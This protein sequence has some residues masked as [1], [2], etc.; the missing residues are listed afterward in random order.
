MIDKTETKSAKLTVYGYMLKWKDTIVLSSVS[1]GQTDRPSKGHT[2]AMV[3]SYVNAFRIT[4]SLW[5][6]SAG[7]AM[8]CIR[9]N[10]VC[11]VAAILSRLQCV[12]IV[13]MST[14]L[15]KY[16]FDVKPLLE[17]VLAYCQIKPNEQNSMKFEIPS[18]L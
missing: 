10:A 16:L 1:T 3:A 11:Q 6:E 7:H 9:K 12:V 8:E 13:R 17:L 5:G 4:G 2:Y 18:S 14:V 15:G